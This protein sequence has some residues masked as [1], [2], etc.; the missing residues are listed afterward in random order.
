MEICVKAAGLLEQWNAQRAGQFRHASPDFKQDALLPRAPTVA[1][2]SVPRGARGE[3][4]LGRR[5][6]FPDELQTS[7][8]TGW[9]LSTLG[10]PSVTTREPEIG[11]SRPNRTSENPAKS[12]NSSRKSPC[13]GHLAWGDRQQQ[14]SCPRRHGGRGRCR[15]STVQTRTRY[16]IPHG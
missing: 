1:G 5:K 15:S 9:T 8:D 2:P 12:R 3:T 6:R 16:P 11:H 14:R 13:I 7:R 10:N 4:V